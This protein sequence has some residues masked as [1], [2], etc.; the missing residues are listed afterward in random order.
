MSTRTFKHC[1]VAFV[2]TLLAAGAATAAENPANKWRIDCNGAATSD[3]QIQFRV[4]PKDGE[5][6]TITAKV[7]SGHGELYIAKDILVAFKAQLPKS[8][9]GSEIIAGDV[10]LIKPRGG[11]A[12]FVV[13][14]VESSVSG[15]KIHVTHE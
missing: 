13:E 12:G 6:I 2:A 9:F 3:G 1:A 5:A 11:E 14:L 7:T 4:T 10:V 15:T 8:R